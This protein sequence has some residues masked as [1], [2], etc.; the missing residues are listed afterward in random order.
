MY[1]EEIKIRQMTNQY[2]IQKTDKLTAVRDLCGVQAQFMSNAIHSLKIRCHDFDERTLAEGLVKNWTIRGTV[3]VF[4]ESDLSLFKHCNNGKNYRS[5]NFCGYGRSDGSKRRWT[6][7]PERQLYFSRLILQEIESGAKTRDELKILCR[8]HGMTALEEDSMF[9]QWG[10]GI[11][12]LC[13][14][15]FMNY[16]VQEKKAYIPAPL[17]TP[18]PE[19][20]ANLEIARRYF[21]H[22]APATMHDAMYFFHATAAQVKA[23]LSELPVSSLSCDGKTYYYIENDTAYEN[24]IPDCVFLAGFD[25][26]MLGYQKKESLYLKE[27]HLRKLFNLAG[28]VMPAVLL[29]GEVIGKW[30]KTGTKLLITLFENISSQDKEM[31]EYQA[32]M[33]WSKEIRIVFEV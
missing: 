22:I 4:A 3:H 13:E 29:R 20:Q 17:F 8:N 21:T 28:I 24:P 12:D 30:K 31:M 9:D 32:K 26:L 15:G 19:A 23:W 10:G 11:R 33:L 1:A 16:A 5:E 18:I 25:Q 14:R 7:T 2:L 6:L 27:E